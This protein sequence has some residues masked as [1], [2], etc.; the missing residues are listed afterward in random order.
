MTNGAKKAA[1]ALKANATPLQNATQNQRF[2][3]PAATA[4]MHGATQNVSAW[5]RSDG[6]KDDARQQENAESA[7]SRNFEDGKKPPGCKRDPDGTEEREQF[8]LVDD[9]HRAVEHGHRAE[10]VQVRGRVI[11][12]GLGERADPSRREDMPVPRLHVEG[13]IARGVLKERD[14][15]DRERRKGECGQRLDAVCRRDRRAFLT[16]PHPTPDHGA[17]FCG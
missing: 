7:P 9:R 3:T 11:A 6:V 4:R 13:E 2:R 10:E 14:G 15:V 17:R 8:D 16:V 12:E 1:C 5:P